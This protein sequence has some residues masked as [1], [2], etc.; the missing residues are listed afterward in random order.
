LLPAG[1]VTFLFTDIE[2]STRLWEDHP[3]AMRA[4]L[5]MHDALV[6]AAIERHNGVVFKTIGDAFCAAFQDA[7][8]AVSAAVESQRALSKAAWP[9][10]LAL[11][12]RMA[13]HTGSVESRDNDY[14]GRPLNRVARLLSIGHGGQVLLPDVTEELCRDLLPEGVTLKRLG[15]H[16]LKDLGRP[17]IVFQL[18]HPEIQ[19]EF[20]PLRSLESTPNNLP[21]QV[22]SFIG[23]EK[24]LAEIKQLLDK[25]RLVTLTGSG[26]CGK[27]RLGLE[28]AADL[29]E[30]CS[31]GAWLVELAPLS[32]PDLV[33][34]TVT[35][36]FG[37][38]EEGNANPTQILVDHLK[39]KQLLLVLDNCEHLLDACAQLADALLRGCPHVVLLA[40][41]R[42][43][44][45][46]SGERTYRVPSLSLPDP[47]RDTTPESL[48]HFEAV[49]LFVER[50]QFHH[51]QFA[52]TE[53]NA[54]A[55]ASV[56]HRLDGIPLAIE[57]AAARVRSLSVEEVNK[58]LDQR[59]RL[60]TGGSRTAL[61]RQQ[62]LRSLIDWSYDLLN[63]AEKSL[64]RRLSA[65]S[66]G[67]M[68][69]SAEHVCS[70]GSVQEG[71]VLDLLTSLS[72]KS[73]VTAEDHEGR[74]R[75]G[76][77]ETVRQYARERLLESGEG[78][79]VRARHRDCFLSL[80]EEIQPKLSGPEQAHWYSVLEEEHGNLRAALTFS[81][82]EAEESLDPEEAEKGLRLGAALQLFW[83]IRGHLQE[84][85]QLL[86][87]LLSLPGSYGRTKARAEALN[88]AGLLAM[89]QLDYAAAWELYEESL[90][91]RRELGDKQGV[92]GSLNNLGIVARGRGDYALA[93]SLYEEALSINRELSNRVWE[94]YNL[95]NLG[96]VAQA[97]GDYPAATAL[98]EESLGIKRELGDRRAIA[99]SLYSL[100]HL[101]YEQKDYSAARALLRDSLEVCREV[102][103]LVCM[104][105]CFRVLGE[106]L[107]VLGSW[108]AAAQLWG[109][110]ERL[111]GETGVL[112]S[113]GDRS[114]YETRLAETRAAMGDTAFQSAWAEGRAMPLEQAMELAFATDED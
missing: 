11:K 53:Q 61:P 5:A 100:G 10:H 3:E 69:E 33:P 31:D 63:E 109:A 110:A 70:G 78:G 91:I 107:A 18:C 7:P 44:L 30:R 29:L 12:V 77:L 57:L 39:S 14:F 106:A 92:A 95:A 105:A 73:L 60:L 98:Q 65:F 8:D 40:T 99:L 28:A 103:D 108:S 42:E 67:W 85:R 102:G 62:T 58:K 13:L 9:D 36:V 19:E 72:D 6:R 74:T 34:Q 81:M 64:L 86:P 94:A 4:A 22:T 54:P 89:N 52:V 114:G 21:Q 25:S 23:R 68:L 76:M 93:R 66:G 47:K 113:T 55:L 97:L 16:R 49:R 87:A 35:N 112:T 56:C 17:E 51:P 38:K 88:G 20:P 111:E 79:T 45:G 83:L 84:G 50:A 1:T 27:T 48:A 75:Y 46:I 82:D 80:A 104:A 32:D 2:G 37:L 41:S 90:A 96:I 26:G 24:E 43:G 71:E 59:F 15:E 101:A